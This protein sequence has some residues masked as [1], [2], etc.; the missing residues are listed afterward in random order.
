MEDGGRSPAVADPPGDP[1]KRRKRKRKTISR[2]EL[3]R[4]SV[5]NSSKIPPVVEKDGKQYMWMGVYWIEN[6]R[7]TGKEVL[8]V[9]YDQ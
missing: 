2:A 8:V 4:L 7:A 3:E 1:V 5:C 6:G 9:D